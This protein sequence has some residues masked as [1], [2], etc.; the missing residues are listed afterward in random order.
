MKTGNV[1]GQENWG[2]VIIGAGQAGLA[3]GYHL[4]KARED[5]IIIDAA[6]KIGDSWRKRWDSL[7]L[8][9]P[10]QYDGL[11]GFLFPASRNNWKMDRRSRFLQL[12]GLQGLNRIFH[13]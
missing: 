1:N 12:S 10:A 2:T 9:T 3:A 13:G 5:F 4:L 8:F 7:R 11:P 6:E